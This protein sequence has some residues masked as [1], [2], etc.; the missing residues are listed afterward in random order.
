MEQTATTHVS[1]ISYPDTMSRQVKARKAQRYHLKQG[2]IAFSSTN[3]CEICN[4]SKT[5]IALQFLTHKGS[6]CED[7]SEINLLNNLEGFLLGQIPCRIAY[8]N[9]T[10]PSEQ[11]SQSVIRKIGLQFI[12]LTPDQQEQIDDLLRKFSTKKDSIH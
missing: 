1:K 9:D 12:N 5:G 3:F 7:M 11:Q 2:F 8:I 4:I 6:D 10:Q